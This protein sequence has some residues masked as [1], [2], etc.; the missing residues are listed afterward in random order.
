MTNK[1]GFTIIELIVVVAILGIL[2][3]IAGPKVNGQIE[4]TKIARI[5]S[6]VKAVE[7]LV[8]ELIVRDGGLPEDWV[9]SGTLPKNKTYDTSGEIKDTRLF[10]VGPYKVVNLKGAG[11]GTS[12]NS[13][14]PG[15]FVA[16]SA[17]KVYYISDVLSSKNGNKIADY[18]SYM[19]YYFDLTNKNVDNLSRYDMVILEP[20]NANKRPE[21][22][23][24]LRKNNTEIYAYQSIM[25]LDN[26]SIMDRMSDEDYITVNGV[27]PTHKHFGYKFG[28]IR[29]EGYRNILLDVIYEDVL[30]KGYDGVFFDT[31]D[32]VN[33]GLFRDNKNPETGVE[34]RTELIE[35]YVEFLRLAKERYPG[36]SIIQNRGFEVY[37]AGGANYVDAVVLEN[38]RSKDF[39]NGKLN[40]LVKGLQGSSDKSNSVILALSYDN[41][42]INYELAKKYNWI[43]TYYNSDNAQNNKLETKEK[44][45]KSNYIK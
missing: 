5:R 11:E 4:K 26:P 43:Y 42:D 29:S 35:G 22:L 16:N 6:D 1:K 18:E 13:K 12:V 40:W 20:R 8:D 28:D 34:I 10:Q 2:V 17:G 23:E 36:L 32:D 30:S 27:K 25:G 3:G 45:Y 38:F 31:F 19:I 24:T 44:V 14:L 39:E 41:P 33:I 21:H 15:Y 9:D 7:L 37:Q